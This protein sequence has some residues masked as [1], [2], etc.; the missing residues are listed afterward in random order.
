MQKCKNTV[1]KR[2]WLPDYYAQSVTDIDFE[3]LYTHE[4]RACLID[5][6]D[7][8]VLHGRL[9]V[10]PGMAKQLRAQ[11]L[12]MYIATNR[13]AFK[14]VGMIAEQIGA[15][16]VLQ[17]N[18]IA[19]KPLRQYYHRAMELTGYQPTQICMIGDHL[20]QDIWGANRAGF[21]TIAVDK[22]GRPP[23]IHRPIALAERLYYHLIRPLYKDIRE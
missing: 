18:G 6:D 12:D 20:L 17:P 21:T 15:K 19:A 23:L 8:I 4:L 1:H 22:L 14:N 2:S 16:G 5:L 13:P 11:P 10:E 7:T 9:E 3:W